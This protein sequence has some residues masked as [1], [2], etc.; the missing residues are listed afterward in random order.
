M[1][2]PICHALMDELSAGYVICSAAFELT[3]LTMKMS[4]I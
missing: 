3:M 2:V 4:R 1:T